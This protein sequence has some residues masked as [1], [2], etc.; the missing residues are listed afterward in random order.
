VSSKLTAHNCCVRRRNE[1]KIRVARRIAVQPLGAILSNAA[2]MIL[3]SGGDR[4]DL[5]RAEAARRRVTL[6]VRPAAAPALLLADRVQIQQVLI[7]LV[8]NAMDAVAELPDD[9]RVVT[10]STDP[11]ADWVRMSVRDHGRGIPPEHLAK[12]FESFPSHGEA[13]APTPARGHHGLRRPAPE[14][15]LPSAE[16]T[17]RRAGGS[18]LVPSLEG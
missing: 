7:D 15:A 5:L 11:P 8:V 6:S 4:R 9:K 18:A 10:V 12:V 14:P 1:N 2:E 3:D 13:R 16:R 17:A